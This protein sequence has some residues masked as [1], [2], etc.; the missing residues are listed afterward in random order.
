M[1]RAR[2]RAGRLLGRSRIINLLYDLDTIIHLFLVAC[3]LLRCLSGR[4]IVLVGFSGD[5]WTKR[6][7]TVPKPHC[8]SV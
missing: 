1:S 3:R 6:C 8:L 2:T 7:R 4:S 5:F